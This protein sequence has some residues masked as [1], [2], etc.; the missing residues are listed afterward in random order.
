MRPFEELRAWQAAHALTLAIYRAT[1][2]LPTHENYGL[3]S[4]LRRA[5]TSIG[6]NIVEGSARGDAEF[7]QFLRISLG[8]AAEVEYQLLLARDLGYLDA[9]TQGALAN[10]LG[11]LKRMLVTFM[12]TVRAPVGTQ[13]R[14]RPTANGQLQAGGI[15]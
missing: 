14:Q 2:S 15:Q 5:A 6:S 9:E 4:Q 8:S 1:A 13:R 11:S 12:K 7:H 3:T 10:D